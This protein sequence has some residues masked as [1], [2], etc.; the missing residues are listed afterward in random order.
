VLDI[1][2]EGI[3]LTSAKDGVVFD[4]EGAGQGLRIAWTSPAAQNAFLVLDRNTNGTI[5]DGT[6]LFG[7]WTSQP[8]S[9]DPNG[10]LALAEFDKPE[11]G[12]NGDG[13]IDVRDRVFTNL[14][15]WIDANHNGI[16]ETSEL[17]SLPALGVDAISLDYKLSSRQDEFG[18]VL[19]YRAKA[20][21]T[22][23]GMTWAYDVMFSIDNTIKQPF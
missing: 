7:N 15:L 23:I 17:F 5:D 10:F 6:E 19:R 11:N 3:T 13:L 12:G 9:T 16:S 4:I 1:A 2:G 22:R 8:K 21:S 20:H 18:N 14:K